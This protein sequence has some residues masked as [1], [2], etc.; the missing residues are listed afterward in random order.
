MRRALALSSG[1]DP[2]E[3]EEVVEAEQTHRGGRAFN[4]K[5]EELLLHAS[6]ESNYEKMP[7]SWAAWL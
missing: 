4:Q 5:V 1:L 2:E 3:E 6:L 7:L